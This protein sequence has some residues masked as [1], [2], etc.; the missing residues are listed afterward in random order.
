M[1][2][3]GTDFDIAVSFA[4]A[5]RDLVE[6]VVRAC[7]ALGVRTFYDRDH[8]VE[9]WGRSFITG[10]REIYSGK[11]AR[12]F[13]PFLSR[14]YLASAYPMDEYNAALPRAIEIGA[15]DYMLPI[16]VGS[17]QVPDTL[18]NPAIG[19]LRMEDHTADELARIIAGRVGTAR[20]RHQEPRDVMGVVDN[21]FGVR[22]P[23]IPTTDFNPHEML[24][25]ALVQVGS[26]FQRHADTLTRFGVQCVV[27]ASDTALDVKIDRQG[28]PLCQLRLYFGS[29][30]QEDHLLMAFQWP[31]IVGG[32]F[33]GWVSAEWDR[34]KGR[35]ALKFIDLGLAG[36]G[37]AIMV[38]ADELFNI[39]WEEIIKHLEATL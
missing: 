1:A 9:F 28:R 35:P 26:H 14:E 38:T 12:Y 32:G 33:N 30:P 19:Y 5:Q 37:G 36:N 13:V 34:D 2:V 18:L 22:L 39:L 27:D 3:T 15:D 4:G 31:R 23:R 10:M 25:A 7:Q 11:R 8:T 20:D 6:P 17:V 21:A 16:I 29:W 24:Q